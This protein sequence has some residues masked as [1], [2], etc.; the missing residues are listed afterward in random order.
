MIKKWTGIC[1]SKC[2][3]VTV[4][5][6]NCAGLTYLCSI[7]HCSRRLQSVRSRTRTGKNLATELEVKDSGDDKDTKTS[8]NGSS[9][10]GNKPDPKAN[11]KAPLTKTRATLAAEEEAEV[12]SLRIELIE[13]MAAT[14]IEE[15]SANKHYLT[16]QDFSKVVETDTEFFSHMNLY[17]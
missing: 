17:L 4:P 8:A 13:A 12:E 14:V 16:L 7:A 1:D 2:V 6:T 3:F 15:A 10:G 5:S 9:S 11:G